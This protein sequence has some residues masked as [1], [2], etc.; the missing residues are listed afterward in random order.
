MDYMRIYAEDINKLKALQIAYK[1][2]IGED[3]PTESDIE[4]LRTAI[5]EEKNLFLRM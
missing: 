1:K 4:S 5:T 2:A 3:T